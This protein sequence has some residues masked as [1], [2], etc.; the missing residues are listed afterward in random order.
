MGHSVKEP[1]FKKL[2]LAYLNSFLKMANKLTCKYIQT[3]KNRMKIYNFGAL[4]ITQ[5]IIAY[6]LS[7]KDFIGWLRCEI[8]SESCAAL[9]PEVSFYGNR[10][11]SNISLSC[12]YKGVNVNFFSFL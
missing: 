3:L 4:G 9:K 10:G 11:E 7:R 2:T 8:M 6:V 1:S 12:W 5:L